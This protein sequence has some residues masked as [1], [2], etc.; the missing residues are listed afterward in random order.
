M[1]V[2]TLVGW[3]F[4]RI[5]SFLKP[6]FP[7]L[8]SF[9]SFRVLRVF[10]KILQWTQFSWRINVSSPFCTAQFEL[11]CTTVLYTCYVFCQEL[12]LYNITVRG[13]WSHPRHQ[14][15]IETTSAEVTFIMSSSMCRL[16]SY[17]AKALH[18]I[19]THIHL[20]YKVISIRV[21]TNNN[22]N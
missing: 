10:V 20:D 14:L 13:Q 11:P 22:C 18:W 3:E 16:R 17:I 19:C 4:T 2:T 7:A 8:S 9:S 6:S 1:S 5:I 15:Y 21:Y 12:A